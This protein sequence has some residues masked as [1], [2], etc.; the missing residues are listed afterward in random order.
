MKK[1][2]YIIIGLICS[3]LVLSG[4]NLNQEPVVVPGNN[5][6]VVNETVNQTNNIT[7]ENLT[8]LNGVNGTVYYN[9]TVI[10]NSL[11]TTPVN[12]TPWHMNNNVTGNVS[13]NFTSAAQCAEYYALKGETALNISQICNITS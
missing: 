6:P 7:A 11:N 13:E 12:T 1:E 5:L 2:M 10:N 8:G 9:E 4:C 3:V